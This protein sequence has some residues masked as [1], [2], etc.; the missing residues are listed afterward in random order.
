MIENINFP[1]VRNVSS[2]TIAGDIKHY[3]PNDPNCVREWKKVT[4]EIFNKVKDELD[5]KGIPMPK[6]VF[7]TSKEPITY[8]VKTTDEN[9]NIIHT[10]P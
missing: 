10:Q 4:D 8:A 3:D 1:Y 6:I 2:K 9:G 7:D 5:A